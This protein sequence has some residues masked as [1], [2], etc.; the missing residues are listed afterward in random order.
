MNELN[1]GQPRIRLFATL[2]CTCLVMM[3]NVYILTCGSAF[4]HSIFACTVMQ[5]LTKPL[6]TINLHS[7]AHR[8]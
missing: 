3:I 8:T 2:V 4:R 1:W 6:F 7:A 5:F